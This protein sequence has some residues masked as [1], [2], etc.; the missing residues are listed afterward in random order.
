MTCAVAHDDMQRPGT[1]DVGS[2]DV[3]ADVAC[4]SELQDVLPHE[5]PVH[6]LPDTDGGVNLP[7]VEEDRCE[8]FVRDDPQGSVPVDEQNVDT[9]RVDET[10]CFPRVVIELCAGCARL[11][12]QCLLQKGSQRWL[13]TMSTTGTLLIIGWCT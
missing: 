3:L 2:K 7:L 11:S 9:K 1:D 6:I 5:E 13:W 8:H 12:I 10:G 4:A